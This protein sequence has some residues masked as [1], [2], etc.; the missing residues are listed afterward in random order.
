MSLRWMARILLFM[1][2]ASTQCHALLCDVTLKNSYLPPAQ[3]GPGPVHY[4]ACTIEMRTETEGVDFNE[5]LRDVYLSVKKRWSEKMPG[6]V[7]K[8]QQGINTVE[9]HISQN[10][11]VPK[12]S[13]K[14]VSSS[15]KADFDAA[16]LRAV[17]EAI[18]FRDLP[19]KFSKPFVVLRFTFYY[20]LPMPR[21]PH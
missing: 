2:L 20:N 15:E 3:N 13:I 9:F 5:Y 14:L 19:D 17:Q 1:F 18:P 4:A 11:S 16:S 10:G 7:T 8:G 12:D 21:N 6:S